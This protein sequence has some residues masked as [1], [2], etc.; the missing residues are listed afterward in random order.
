MDVS[1]YEE[2]V[3]V[4]PNTPPD[5][6][7]DTED[8]VIVNHKDTAAS[9]TTSSQK[10]N[11]NSSDDEFTCPRRIMPADTPLL[12]EAQKDHKPTAPPILTKTLLLGTPLL[13]TQSCHHPGGLT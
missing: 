1:V 11:S 12:A 10:Y 9:L 4:A 2:A 3:A 7:P 5:T 6:Y 8:F 13:S